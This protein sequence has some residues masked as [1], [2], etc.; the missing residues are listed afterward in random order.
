LTYRAQ[1]KIGVASS[2]QGRLCRHA[3]QASRRPHRG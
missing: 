2:I 1:A 3:V